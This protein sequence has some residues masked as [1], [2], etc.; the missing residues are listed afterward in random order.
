MSNY[1]LFQLDRYGDVLPPVE[2]M[3]SGE[4]E[5][6]EEE[7]QRFQEW[8]Q[9]QNDLQMEAAENLFQDY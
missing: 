2:V 3:P 1:E 8:S 6:G 4:C 7:R 5:N 9:L